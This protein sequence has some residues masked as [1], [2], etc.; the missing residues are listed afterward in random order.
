MPFSP[1]KSLPS[2]YLKRIVK[3]YY[4]LFIVIIVISSNFQVYSLETAA[5]GIEDEIKYDDFCLNTK[6]Y[7]L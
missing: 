1:Q 7:G 6:H 4:T 2:F 3:I 5:M